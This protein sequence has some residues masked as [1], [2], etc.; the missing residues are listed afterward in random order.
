MNILTDH[1]LERLLDFLA[2]NEQFVF[3]DTTR[4]DPE[5]TT[6]LLFLNPAKRL[7]FRVGDDVY[8]F[9]SCMEAELVAGHHLAGW[10]AYEMG[11]LLEENLSGLLGRPEDAGLLLVDLGVFASP[12]V[13]DHFSGESTF[14]GSMVRET[15]RIPPQVDSLRT[16]LDQGE[17]LRAIRAIREYILAG[18]TYQVNYTLKLLFEFTGSPETFYAAL[19]RNQSVA[20][21]AYLR[22]GEERILSF[23]PELFFASDT[24]K[25]RVR[26]MKGT[27][28]RGRFLN[29]DLQNMARLQNDTKNRSEN[30]MIVDL[31]RN[32]LGRLMRD[33]DDAPVI[34]RSLF[35]VE[36]YETLLQ[37]TSTIEARTGAGRI[38]R[39]PSVPLVSLFRALFPCGS[40]TG[41]PKVRTMEII[42]ELEPLRRG[43]YTGAI[44]YLAPGGKVFFN[45]PI[46][47]VVLHGSHGEIGVGSGI[48]A[49]SD[50]E[51]EWQECLLKGRF[52]TAPAPVFE[53]IETLLWEPGAGYWLL[54]PHL[55]R[56]T[57][58]ASYFLFTCKCD[59][60]CQE[61][62]KIAGTFAEDPMR[63]RLTLAKDGRLQLTAQVCALP[64]ARS[65]PSRPSVRVDGMP[66]I[67]LSPVRVDSSDPWLFHKTTRR[68]LYDRE[69]R[70]AQADGVFDCWFL[71][72]REELTEGCISTIILYLDGIYKTPPLNCGLL[73]GIMRNRLLAD[74]NICLQEEVLTLA[75]MQRA[76]A[77]FCC[78]SV[79][80]VVQVRVEEP[81]QQT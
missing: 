42:N 37:M 60:I 2:S 22:F 50:P 81:W 21:G 11:Y 41:A 71:N 17:Y 30:V 9:F 73:A 3:L 13:F 44:G 70:T 61:L 64:V 78:N 6:S 12:L 26:P 38:S 8:Q 31:L 66:R 74:T 58:S 36:R 35:D 47:T 34:S 46:R 25:I 43:V 69:W 33:F 32:D 40:V 24:E 10:F 5:N 19:R 7:Q 57:Q 76:D 65:L 1:E 79:R 67:R 55:E 56:L 48:V 63:V 54:D 51:Q 15:P 27:A 75:D 68:Q 16:S 18:D 62:Q 29:E 49:D 52:L 4:P 80:G 45:V 28:S 39:L 53:L 20:Y 14:P 77:V 59:R 23:S 72:E